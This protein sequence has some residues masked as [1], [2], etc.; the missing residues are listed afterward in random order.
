[1]HVVKIL[2]GKNKN[3][4]YAGREVNGRVVMTIMGGKVTYEL[5]EKKKGFFS[6]LFGK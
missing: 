4:P 5:R 2:V 3:M 1:M 6:R